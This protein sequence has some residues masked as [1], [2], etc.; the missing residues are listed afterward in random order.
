M[1]CYPWKTYLKLER[2]DEAI[3]NRYNRWTRCHCKYLY[4]FFV[5]A[6]D[7]RFI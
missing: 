6:W 7:E 3:L 5:I 2:T 4:I 1:E